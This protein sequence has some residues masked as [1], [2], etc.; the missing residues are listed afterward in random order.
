[1][2]F[3]R[4]GWL[5]TKEH[6]NK[7]DKLQIQILKNFKKETSLSTIEK[8]KRAARAVDGARQRQSKGLVFSQ[9]EAFCFGGRWIAV[10]LSA[11][12][13]LIVC[14]KGMIVQSFDF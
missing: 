1:M 8:Q 7:K 14:G 11:T 13:A 9:L 4:A 6:Q 10:V 12:R 5:E 3:T 2:L